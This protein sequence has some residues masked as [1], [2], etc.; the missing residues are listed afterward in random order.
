[1]CLW[2]WNGDG[3]TYVINYV[4]HISLINYFCWLSLLMTFVSSRKDKM[5][6]SMCWINYGQ[7]FVKNCFHTMIFSMSVFLFG[8]PWIKLSIKIINICYLSFFSLLVK[9][10]KIKLIK[11]S[12]DNGLFMWWYHLTIQTHITLQARTV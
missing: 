5:S 1:M 2:N 4:A 9:I 3:H 6:I 7:N 11:R 12:F 10:C 8:S